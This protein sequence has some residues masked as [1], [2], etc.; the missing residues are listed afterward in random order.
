MSVLF[1]HLPLTHHFPSPQL[2]PSA[3]GKCFVWHTSKPPEVPVHHRVVHVLAASGQCLDSSPNV[4]WHWR[5]ASYR[6]P[7]RSDGSLMGFWGLS[8]KHSPGGRKRQLLKH[9]W[10]KHAKWTECGVTRY[11]LCET[12]HNILCDCSISGKPMPG[13]FKFLLRH[14][15][16]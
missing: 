8:I 14:C 13:R 12:I 11:L 4:N 2:V 16:Q 15:P 1:T 9:S 5:L 10:W 6:V 3:Q 7:G